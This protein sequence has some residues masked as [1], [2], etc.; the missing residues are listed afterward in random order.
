MIRALLAAVLATVPAGA[1]EIDGRH[2]PAES[3]SSA[4]GAHDERH[5]TLAEM[6]QRGILAT[7]MNAWSPQDLA[8]LQ[9]MRQAEAAG[10]PGFLRRHLPSWQ[11][12]VLRDR[13]AGAARL[14]LTR[15]GFEKYLGI[16]SQEALQYFETKDIATKW[17]YW[18][19][20][21]ESRP[22]FDRD[23][24]LLTAAG[25]ALYSQARA[26]QPV[27]WRLRTGA[28]QGNRPVPPQLQPHPAPPPEPPP[29]TATAAS[30]APSKSRRPTYPRAAHAVQQ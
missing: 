3:L 7:D 2:A 20:D 17:A 24:G 13:T 11:G 23:T 1:A 6:W 5:E 10:A 28:I 12:L 26:N 22:L 29:A 9:R 21:I 19:T 25:D 4:A 15:L 27:F 18:L 16:K 8:L 14:R 30:T